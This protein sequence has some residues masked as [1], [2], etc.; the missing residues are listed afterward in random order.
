MC[1]YIVRVLQLRL[2][3]GWS[4]VGDRL[5][6]DVG[7]Y[8]ESGWYDG[9]LSV[10]PES[11]RQRDRLL[12]E[13]EVKPVLSRLKRVGVGEWVRCGLMGWLHVVRCM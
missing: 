5:R 9:F 12:F 3:V 10:K 6:K 7:Y 13:M 2:W 8:E 11:I 1:V 4:Y